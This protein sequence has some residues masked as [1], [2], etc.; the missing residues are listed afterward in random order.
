MLCQQGA[1]LRGV[2]AARDVV[3]LQ[4][5][6]HLS[7]IVAFHFVGNEKRSA[8]G[9]HR[10]N[11]FHRCIESERR[12][13]ADA[14]LACN[15]PLTHEEMHQVGEG[16]MGYHDAFR[17]TRGTRS[18]NHISGELL[19]GRGSVHLLPHHSPS[20][21]RPGFVEWHVGS[22]G[23]HDAKD[24][25]HELQAAARGQTDERLTHRLRHLGRQALQLAIGDASVFVDNGCPVGGQS[26]L[27]E[28]HVD[29]GFAFI[30][31]HRGSLRQRSHLGFLL[32]CL[33]GNVGQRRFWME[34]KV[35]GAF[36]HGLGHDAA[37]LIAAISSSVNEAAVAECFLLMELETLSRLPIKV[38]FLDDVWTL[39][40]EDH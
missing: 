8:Y 36:G 22:P 13:A 31:I 34:S 1:K 39:K 3:A 24:R 30:E 28:N 27:T 20:L 15:A 9:Q 18:E 37:H 6:V 40:T 16:T 4:E 32:R 33:H 2:A 26:C 11:V 21:L 17:L 29:H 7:Q 5:L 12:M 23:A 14:A 19:T 25:N 38:Y 10:K 35:A